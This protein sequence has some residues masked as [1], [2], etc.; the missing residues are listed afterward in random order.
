[1]ASVSLP[2]PYLLSHQIGCVKMLQVFISYSHN[3]ADVPLLNELKTHLAGLGQKIKVWVDDQIPPGGDWDG[4]IHEK[5]NEAD[6]VLLLVSSN[7]IASNYINQV[8]VPQS[9]GRQEA[10]F[11]EVVPVFLRDC[12]FKDQPYAHLEFLPKM[13]VNQKLIAIGDWNNRDNAF[14]TV[15][16]RLND[17]VAQFFKKPSPGKKTAPPHKPDTP[18]ADWEQFFKAHPLKLDGGIA[19]TVN[20]DRIKH[21]KEGL[22]K[23]FYKNRKEE[24]SLAYFISACEYQKPAS[25]AKRLIYELL[26]KNLKIAHSRI[27]TNSAELAEI[28]LKIGLEPEDTW[29]EAW[30]D[31]LQKLNAQADSP[32]ELAIQTHCQSHD[33][34]A[35]VFRANEKRWEEPE[36]EEHL[37]HI[38]LKFNDLPKE[39]RKFILFFVFDFHRA[40]SARLGECQDHLDKLEDLI[41]G[42]NQ[43]LNSVLAAHFKLMPPVAP[44]DVVLWFKDRA[45]DITPESERSLLKI[46]KSQLDSED[47]KRPDFDMEKVE[48]MQLAAWQHINKQAGATI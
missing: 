46:L 18:T 20:C 41:S 13:S 33:K 4:F 29:S 47:Q 45:Q 11:C 35:L 43:N 44:D 26:S 42:I 19:T 25:L 1:M 6:I 32:E 40:D 34:I 22:Q 3:A 5:L 15:V 12:Y 23:D 8:E 2:L 16:E 14:K 21:F 36:L 28:E 48:K 24:K 7:Y 38:V 10:G 9:L 30:K 39:A 31:V 27:A 37:A 17:L